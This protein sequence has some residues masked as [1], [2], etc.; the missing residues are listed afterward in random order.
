MPRSLAT[1]V[2][3]ATGFLLG[4]LAAFG[5]GDPAAA[6]YHRSVP[7]CGGEQPAK[8]GG[9]RYT[10]TFTDD[11]NKSTLDLS[12]WTVGTTARTGFATARI[13]GAPDCYVNSTKNVWVK[14]GQL[15]LR[16][17][18]EAER[19]V[20]HSP[21]GKFTTNKTAGSVM[22]W[23]KFAQA[24]GRFEFRAKFPKT[25]I[26][27]IDSALWMNPQ[28]PAYGRWPKSGEIDVAEWFGSAHTDHVLPSVHYQGDNP[29]VRTARNC[30]VPRADSR[31]HRYAVNWTKTT[32]YFWYDG[33][34]CLKH[35]WKPGWP[36][37]SPQPFDRP[38]YLV[39]TQTGG[40]DP[41]VG[42]TTTM[43]VDWVRVWK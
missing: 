7:T 36:L 9:G 43:D 1:A 10:C 20:C 16:T 11:F 28:T 4:S 27:H 34:L 19:F 18:A 5:T 25:K 41:P 8:P 31:F 38:F 26:K 13:S 32:M 17:R 6:S 39:M 29:N 33:K 3:C 37:H 15:H 12:K 23:G 35:A 40:Q 42:T 30:V 22:G 24:Y 14:G 21:Y 2:L